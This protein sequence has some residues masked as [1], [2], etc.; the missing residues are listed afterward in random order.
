MLPN[1]CVF[2]MLF[3]SM[4]VGLNIGPN[5]GIS[6]LLTPAPWFNAGWA[7]AYLACLVYALFQV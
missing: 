6:T 2:L 3:L 4:Q 1:L 7:A 5:R